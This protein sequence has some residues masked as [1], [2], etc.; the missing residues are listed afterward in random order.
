ML[1]PGL[2]SIIINYSKM[3]CY[4]VICA[5]R[6]SDNSISIGKEGVL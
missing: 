1:K 4:S 3:D 5:V 6:D 2:M